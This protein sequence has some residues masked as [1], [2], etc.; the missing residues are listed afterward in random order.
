[1]G[2]QDRNGRSGKE[3]QA[4]RL[5][6][7]SPYFRSDEGGGSG[8][9]LN[10]EKG[11]KRMPGKRGTTASTERDRGKDFDIFKLEGRINL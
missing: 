11:D 6:S 4:E 3:V 10:K 1:M 7:D 8:V 2:E 5:G 9:R